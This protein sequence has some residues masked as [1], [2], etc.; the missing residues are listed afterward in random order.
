MRDG[1]PVKER[2]FAQL[3]KNL[4]VD[5]IINNFDIDNLNLR[6]RLMYSV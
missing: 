6:K 4:D 3:I 1:E 2:K 5:R